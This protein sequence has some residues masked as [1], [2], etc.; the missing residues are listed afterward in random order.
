MARLV[1][2]SNRVPVPRVRGGVAAGGLAVALNDA[3]TPG[4][5]WFGWSGKIAADGADAPPAIVEAR[6]VVYATVDLSKRDYDHFYVGLS[7]G[8]LWPLFH[9]R[10]ALM[11]FR[12]EDYAGYL[13][14]NLMLAR[15]LAALLRP[16]DIVWVHDYHLIPL[17][18]F[19]REAGVR[20]R[21]GFF[22]HVPFA[23]PTVVATL[24]VA[25]EML[26]DLCAYDVTAFQTGSHARDFRDGA[27]RLIGATVDGERVVYKGRTTIAMADA[28]GIDAEAFERDAVR[29]ARSAETERLRQSLEGKALALGVDRLDYSK[30][31]PNRFEGYARMLDRHAELRGKVSFLQIAARS[32]E[33]VSAYR[34]LRRELDRMVGDINGRFS[35]FDWTPLRYI[36]RATPRLMIAGFFR[37]AR[38][39]VVTPLHDG[40]NLVA[41]EYVAAQDPLDPGVLVLSRFAGAAEEL[42]EAILVNPYDPDDIAE[43]MHAAFTMSLEERVARHGALRAKVFHTTANF[44]SARFLNVLEGERASAGGIG[45]ALRQLAEG[46]WSSAGARRQRGAQ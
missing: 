18:R 32:R 10:P 38:V 46:E 24:P 35:E 23:P 12:R 17:A 19:L 2:V 29:A 11:K 14:V 16:D 21:I 6:G 33:D 4:S 5:M 9:F 44:F 28:I 30:G 40:M 25:E 20:N 42:T 39:G 34:D 15:K 41:K 22:L 31:L 8:A 1:I 27:E 37:T 13:R 7:N 26:G 43:A 3:L 36:S 45:R